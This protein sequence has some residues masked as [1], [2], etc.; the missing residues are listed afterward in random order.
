VISDC[1][2]SS[3]TF[4][5]F[6]TLLCPFSF[7]SLGIFFVFNLLLGKGLQVFKCGAVFIIFLRTPPIAPQTFL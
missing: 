1:K 4:L 5:A 3:Q 7:P 2:H 6:V